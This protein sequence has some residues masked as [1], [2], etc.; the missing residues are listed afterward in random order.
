M[1]TSAVTAPSW[2]LTCSACGTPA[3]LVAESGPAS[4]CGSCGQ[5]LFARYEGSRERVLAPRWDAW[6]YRALMPLLDGEAPVS[7]GEGMT[8]LID[9]PDLAAAI[10]VRRLW[11]KDEGQNPTGSFKARGMTAAV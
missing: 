1:N 5:P 4:V 9:A 2:S 8:P 6:R 3:Q 11:I 7:L 10:G